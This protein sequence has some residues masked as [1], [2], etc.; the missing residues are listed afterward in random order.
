MLKT[1][2]YTSSDPDI[3]PTGDLESPRPVFDW[4][5]ALP[6]RHAMHVPDT[7]SIRKDKACQHQRPDICNI[8]LH[9]GFLINLRFGLAISKAIHGAYESPWGILTVE[10][11]GLAARAFAILCVIPIRVP[12]NNNSLFT[13]ASNMHDPRTKNGIYRAVGQ[14]KRL[15]RPNARKP[16]IREAKRGASGL[17]KDSLSSIHQH[18]GFVREV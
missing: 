11:H 5:V 8:V 18:L 1:P 15:P 10:L 3:I 4:I 16:E 17:H 12:T 6:L 14:S 13:T 2:K 7:I 9:L